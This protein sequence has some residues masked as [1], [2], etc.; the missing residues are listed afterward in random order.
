M[1]ANMADKE[2]DKYQGLDDEG[3][4]DPLE[5]FTPKIYEKNLGMILDR[6]GAGWT[7]KV[8]GQEK[9]Y[10][11]VEKVLVSGSTNFCKNIYV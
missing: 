11:D 1:F 8:S 4:R 9:N 10:R 2:S 6:M 3:G 7:N 5:Y